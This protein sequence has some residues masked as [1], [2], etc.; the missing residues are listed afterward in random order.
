MKTTHKFLLTAFLLVG[1]LLGGI[2]ACNAVRGSDASIP[3][4]TT[5]NTQESQPFNATD[6]DPTTSGDSRTAEQDA[7]SFQY[8]DTDQSGSNKGDCGDSVVCDQSTT[9]IYGGTVNRSIDVHVGDDIV[10]NTY[11]YSYSNKNGT[12]YE[13]P[14]TSYETNDITNITNV[15][16]QSCSPEELPGPDFGLDFGGGLTILG[17]RIFISAETGIGDAQPSGAL[18]DCGSEDVVAAVI[19]ASASYL[20]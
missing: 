18:Y 15:V 16:N 11:T 19:E 13:G 12:F 6:Y 1:L 2:A 10:N 3:V 14:V 20:R 4:T 17:K 7:A 5:T 9:N 8:G